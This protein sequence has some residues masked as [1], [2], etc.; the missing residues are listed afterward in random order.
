MAACASHAREL[1][2]EDELADIERVVADPGDAMQRRRA[3]PEP[4]LRAV[5]EE[6]SGRFARTAGEVRLS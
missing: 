2:C 3:G 1:G 5:L 6:M 4:D